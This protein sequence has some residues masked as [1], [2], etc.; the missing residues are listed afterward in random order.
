MG[1]FDMQ[2]PQEVTPQYIKFLIERLRVAINYMDDTNFPSPISASSVDVDLVD[3]GWTEIPIPLV[4]P[5]E[6]VGT[7]ST[8]GA[9]LGGYYLWKPTIY[10]SGTWYLE[11]SIAVGSGGTATC[12]LTGA[13]DIGS[14]STTETTLTLVRSA[15][16]TMPA[17]AQ[18]I[19]VKI[20]T[21]NAS[22]T[23]TIG[24][25]RLIFVPS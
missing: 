12:T 11:A 5:A 9:S 24:G 1:H 23:A 3:L 6:A 20:A 16:L 15:S 21:D 13:A 8:T 25:A 2:P 22:Y 7:T 14:V 19:W 10:P 4:L 18:N 17:V